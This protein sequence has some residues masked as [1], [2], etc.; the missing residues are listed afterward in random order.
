M[1]FR[2]W[3]LAGF[4][5]PLLLVT[6]CQPSAALETDICLVLRPD[7]SWDMTAR[8]LFDGTQL[9]GFVD[10]IPSTLEDLV[11]EMQAAG[12]DVEYTWEAGRMDSDGNTPYTITLSGSD[13]VSLN[14]VIAPEPVFMQQD[15]QGEPRLYMALD[16]DI[17][18]PPGVENWHFTLAGLLV[19]SSNGTLLEETETQ[20]ENI[21]GR[22][23]AV[24]NLAEESDLETPNTTVVLIGLLILGGV[25]FF[26]WLRK[27]K[28]VV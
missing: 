7:E 9:P 22:M 1:K 23:T 18:F 20:W 2:K 21:A 28:R 24:L 3:L 10:Q 26:M 27:A 13:L 5:V 8:V 19:I 15:V 4:L 25:I 12:L 14:G 6:A 11:G 16:P 17:L